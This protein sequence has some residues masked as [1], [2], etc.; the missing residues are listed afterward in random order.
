MFNNPDVQ[1]KKTVLEKMGEV[2]DTLKKTETGS[3]HT[4]Q[5]RAIFYI[6]RLLEDKSVQRNYTRSD[7]AHTIR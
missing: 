1:G 5:L 2:V 3:D 7:S 6:I 4:Q